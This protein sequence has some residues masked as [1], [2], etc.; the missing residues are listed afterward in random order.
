MNRC[1][2]FLLLWLWSTQAVAQLY[3]PY[4]HPYR[5]SIVGEAGGLSPF[6]SGNVEYS[7]LQAR[8]GFVTVRMGIGYTTQTPSFPASLTYNWLLD[9]R[10]KGCPPRMPRQVWF[11]EAGVGGVL[12]PNRGYGIQ[13]AWSP[14]MGV[15]RYFAVSPFKRGFVKAQLLTYSIEGE[16]R[17][18]GGLSLGLQVD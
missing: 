18:W 7:P 5:W 2:R 11:A 3:H 14:L 17:P 15:R 4:E 8:R 13:A 16:L 10:V 9:R 12:V 6:I 1:L